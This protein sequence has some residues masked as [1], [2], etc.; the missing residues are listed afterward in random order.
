[1]PTYEYRC[2][3]CK[4]E[5]EV[6]QRMVDDDLVHCDVCGKDALE[7]LISHTAFQ[8]KG[9]GWYK[10]LYSSTKP[11]SGGSSDKSSTTSTTSSESSSTSSSSDS[12]S[13]SSTPAASSSSGSGS[14]GSSGSTTSAA[15]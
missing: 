11:D 13:S 12:S 8:F 2:N 10:D 3:A 7:K 9:G 5:F 14:S 1:V 15:S 6:Q 4:R